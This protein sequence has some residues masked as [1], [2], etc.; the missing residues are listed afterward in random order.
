MQHSK[1]KPDAF[2]REMMAKHPSLKSKMDSLSFWQNDPRSKLMGIWR[3]YT[4]SNLELTI[5]V[6]D[7]FFMLNISY[8][9]K[10]G[11]NIFTSHA[12][13]RGETDRL[14]YFIYKG[15]IVEIM[16]TGD[17]DEEGEEDGATMYIDDHVFI[18]VE[19]TRDFVQATQAMADEDEVGI[20]S[21]KYTD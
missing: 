12:L 13:L 10:K 16:V 2:V 20:E 4:N 18:H 3:C 6:Q 11:K 8:S 19:G 7:N 9:R 21:M 14:Y 17:M 1:F 15:K 5:S